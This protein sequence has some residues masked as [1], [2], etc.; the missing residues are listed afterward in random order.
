M[1]PAPAANRST[2]PSSRTKTLRSS[3][4]DRATS[5]WPTPA[6]IPTARNSSSPPSKPRGST[7]STSSSA[8]SSRASTSSRPSK[9]WGASP[10]SPSRRSSSPNAAS[11]SSKATRT[12][13]CESSQVSQ[14]RQ[15]VNRLRREMLREGEVITP[16]RGE[17][18]EGREG[19]RRGFVAVGQSSFRKKENKERSERGDRVGWGEKAL[20]I[21]FVA[22]PP[23]RGC[24]FFLSL[25]VASCLCCVALHTKQTRQDKRVFRFGRRRRMTW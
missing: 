14:L 4:T 1:V 2:A 7:A 9:R 5:P 13:P 3:T 24:C 15:L 8:R 12:P 18:G 21:D 20:L 17:K 19:R 16:E 6:R 22:R 23:R 10:A 25:R 11:S